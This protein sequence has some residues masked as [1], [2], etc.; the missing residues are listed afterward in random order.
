ME[1]KKKL[2]FSKYT[3]YL[4]YL[5]GVLL[6]WVSLQISPLF[7]NNVND[8]MPFGLQTM[9]VQHTLFLFIVIVLMRLPRATFNPVPD[10]AD[11][12]PLPL[13]AIVSANCLATLVVCS[14]SIGNIDNETLTTT[15]DNFILLNKIQDNEILNDQD[16][17]RLEKLYRPA[18]YKQNYTPFKSS[19]IERMTLNSEQKLLLDKFDNDPKYLSRLIKKS[20]L[21]N[22]SKFDQSTLQRIDSGVASILNQTVKGAWVTK[23]SRKNLAKGVLVPPSEIWTREVQMQNLA[24]IHDVVDYHATRKGTTTAF[25][26]QE[27]QSIIK[28]NVKKLDDYHWRNY[29]KLKMEA[30]KS[31]ER[32]NMS[33]SEK[34]GLVFGRITKSVGDVSND[35][36]SPVSS[37]LDD[38]KKGI[39]KGRDD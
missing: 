38:F 36:F 9:I 26:V 24:S 32:Q 16:V 19:T 8:L 15:S 34:S 30:D 11:W 6:T 31:L 29:S 33:I 2:Y 17:A 35:L 22:L 28:R 39:D 37:A 4:I 20:S 27:L 18:L 7:I 23:K 1:L 3:K 25:V 12:R 10:D 14:L 21:E 5:L 13:W